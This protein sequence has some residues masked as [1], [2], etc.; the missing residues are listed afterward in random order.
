MKMK[1]KIYEITDIGYP[2]I[3]YKRGREK[4]AVQYGAQYDDNLSLEEAA[5]NIGFAIFHA[6]ECESKLD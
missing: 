2:I 3:L 1:K 4:Y 6:L 5:E